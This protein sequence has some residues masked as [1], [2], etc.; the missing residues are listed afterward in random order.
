MLALKLFLVPGFLLLVS[1]AAR[2][3]GPAMG[4][5]LAG[6]PI[7]TGPILGFIALEQGAVF[8]AQAAGGSLMAV[9]STVAVTVAYAH[10]ARVARWPVAVAAAMATW[11]LVA[12]CL[13]L[14]PE[15]LALSAA[16]AGASWLIAPRLFPPAAASGPAP[17]SDR[18][19]LA[20]RMVAGALLSLVVTQV[21]A[22]AGPR[23]SGLLAVFPMMSIVLAGFSHRT[24]G[25]AYTATLL[26]G[27]ARGLLSFAAFC[28]VAAVLLPMAGTAAGFAAAVLAALL[29]Q[30]ATLRRRPRS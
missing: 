24:Q 7:V 22:S 6:L 27:L 4:G 26:R 16:L 8:A 14:L 9:V 3:W 5:W 10:A 1:L 23:W 11:M 20:L 28:W 17:A 13:S 15:S 18:R 21:A 19:E 12:G 2:R 29:A 30:L 25:P